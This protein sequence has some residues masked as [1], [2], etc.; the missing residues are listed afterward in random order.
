MRDCKKQ[1]DYGSIMKKIKQCIKNTPLF[2]IPIMYFFRVI[3]GFYNY[4]YILKKCPSDQNSRIYFMDYDGSG[5]T[6][7]TCSYLKSKGLIGQNDCFVASG[8]LSLKIAELFD[9]GSYIKLPPKAALTVRMMERFYGGRLKF[10][11]LLYES[12]YLEYSGLLR[13]MAGYHGLNFM[14]LLR[15]GFE[16][17]FDLPYDEIPWELPDFPHNPEE[18]KE[19]FQRYQLV[20]GRTVLIAPYAGKHDLWDIP[21]SF[22]EKLA[23]RL[24]EEDFIV[25]TNSSNPRREPA[26]SDTIPLLVPHRLVRAF[27]EKA[28]YFIG[29]R[30]GLCDMISGAR[31]CKKVILYGNMPIPSLTASHREFFSLNGMELC[32]D[33]V[34]LEFGKN[35]QQMVIEICQLF[36]KRQEE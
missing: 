3:R 16:A 17:N 24:R 19:I 15:V 5:D 20:P 35:E 4:R 11:P 23:R 36:G 28:G 14:R 31:D 12:D 25:C 9:F 22:Y 13:R 2:A 8:G 32:E 33:A 10:L 21:I 18:I 26:I 34:E 7:I 27:C 6:Y 30:S 29:L 1:K